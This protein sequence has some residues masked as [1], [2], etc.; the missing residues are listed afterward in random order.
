MTAS[1]TNPLTTF[2]S[3]PF[4]KLWVLMLTAFIDMVGAL[5]VIPLLPVYAKQLGAD[6][7]QL[8]I[9]V[10]SFS[11]AQ[12]LSAPLWGRVSDR[13]GRRPA[14]LIGLGASALGYVVFAF[15]NSIWLILLSRVIQGAGGGTT[16][17]IQAYVA[18]AV[19]PKNRA[20]ALGWLSAAT[21]LGV[22]LGPAIGSAMTW[23]ARWAPGMT[24]A[25]LCLINMVFAARFL[26]ESHTVSARAQSKGARSPAQ[27]VWRVLR[28]PGEV[29]SRLIWIY[30]IAIGAFYGVNSLISFFLIE[31]FGVTEKTI[32]F[33]FM[34]MGSLNVVF[35]VFLLGRVIDR[36]GEAKTVRL[37][38]GF[39]ATGLALIP[40][41]RTY[42]AL[43]I[44]VAFLPLG[45][46]FAFPSVTAL[47]S[48][49]VSTNER[50]LVMGVQ[51]TFG[52]VMRVIYPPIAGKL[53]VLAG[54]PLPFLTSSVLVASTILMGL[55]L[56]RYSEPGTHEVDISQATKQAAEEVAN[57]V[58]TPAVE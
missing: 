33:F 55:G 39:L 15:A 30:M 53:W 56:Q 4:G 47:L 22:T 58:V 21:N 34:Y 35:R 10:A 36:L 26:T 12:L 37:G 9:I 57:K 40:F 28:H 3:G 2:R 7:F 51:Q 13:Y 1:R 6:A 27:A 42:P 43:A 45:A 49:V 54:A 24:A 46:T 14:L 17:V 52:G 5:M 31:R 23:V 32:G 38:T 11:A 20:K 48:Q 18:D 41:V 19:E 8:G 25:V 29:P 16:G 44:A 50:G